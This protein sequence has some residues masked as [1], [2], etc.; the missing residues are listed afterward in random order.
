MHPFIINYEN[1]ADVM[2]LL[3]RPCH[4]QQKTKDD[5]YVTCFGSCLTL[6][7][8]LLI[9]N[10]NRSG[11]ETMTS[12]SYTE[13]LRASKTFKTIKSS[14]SLCPNDQGVI[15]TDLRYRNKVS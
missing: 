12:R 14:L 13:H 9:P 6:A 3:L 4:R 1:M 8:G 7:E 10:L 15:R 11:F 5:Q 2:I